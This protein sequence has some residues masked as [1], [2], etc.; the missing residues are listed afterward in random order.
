VF[1]IMLVDRFDA[2]NTFIG[3]LSAAQSATMIVAYVVVGRLIDRGSSVR[4]TFL[5]TLLILLVPLG[6]IAAPQYWF[7]LPVA[8]VAGIAQAS[9][10]LTY[11]TNL[12]QL[13]P[14]N[15]LADYA[16]AQSLLLGIRGSL[17]PFAA[18]ALLGIYEPR[19]VLVVGFAFMVAGTVIMTGAVREPRLVARELVQ[20]GAA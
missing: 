7:L 5:G 19:L 18:S 3:I 12:V 8:V 1:P 16:A 6:Y 2:P 10:E 9:G 13:A 14:R 17:A 11:H 4:Q 15:R 20:P